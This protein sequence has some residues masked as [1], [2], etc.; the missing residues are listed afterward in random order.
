KYNI[1]TSLEGAKGTLDIKA[2][3]KVDIT[4]EDSTL[5]DL[6]DLDYN[7]NSEYKAIEIVE[8]G[9]DGSF[10]HYGVF[11]D[12]KVG[13]FDSYWKE[14]PEDPWSGD[15]LSIL[16]KED[17]T[18]TLEDFA[19]TYYFI[20]VDADYGSFELEYVNETSLNLIIP[21][22]G[23]LTIEDIALDNGMATFTKN[24]V[25]LEGDSENWSMMLLPGEMIV[26]GSETPHTFG[27]EFGGLLIGI[28]Q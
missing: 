20:D 2:D 23:S 11:L 3:S 28:K 25:D 8:E 19:G 12:G 18:I 21:E 27:G 1:I 26:L 22:E 14:Q 10:R 17:S 13:I 6:V 5:I 4:F 7:Y 24:I 16:V 9:S 15:G